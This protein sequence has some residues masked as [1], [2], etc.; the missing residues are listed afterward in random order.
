MRRR[1][2]RV[3]LERERDYAPVRATSDELVQ[4]WVKLE[5]ADECS[6]TLEEG[7]AFSKGASRMSMSGR[8]IW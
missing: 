3:R 2:S 4:V 6:V 7:C 5:L 1:K 8:A